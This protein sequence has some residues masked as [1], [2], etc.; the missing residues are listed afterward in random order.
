[1]AGAWAEHASGWPLRRPGRLPGPGPTAACGPAAWQ[2]CRCA[3]LWR[4]DDP[5]RRGNTGSWRDRT[6]SRKLRC[7]PPTHVYRCVSPGPIIAVED[8]RRAGLQGLAPALVADPPVGP[9]EPQAGATRLDQQLDAVGVAIAQLVLHR[10]VVQAGLVREHTFPLHLDRPGMF[11]VVG[12]LSGIDLVHAPIGE[13]AA[14]IIEDVA[15]LLVAAAVGSIGSCRGR[16]QP[17]VVVKPF[18][19]R[20]QPVA[21]VARRCPQAA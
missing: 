18:R 11:R 14:G 12:P 19:N 15:P 5:P 1:M 21:V 9:F 4:S 20:L 16:A 8:L 17:H 7:S 10:R 2:C 13:L 3:G 6:Q